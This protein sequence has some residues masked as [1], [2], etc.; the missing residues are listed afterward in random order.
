M[1]RTCPVLRVLAYCRAGHSAPRPAIRASTRRWPSPIATLVGFS[2]QSHR[3]AATRKESLPLRSPV[4]IRPVRF[5][6][7]AAGARP[8]IASSRGRSDPQPG[9]GRPLSNARRGMRGGAPRLLPR[10]GADQT[11]ACAACTV[12]CATSGSPSVAMHRWPGPPRPPRCPPPAYPARRGRPGQSPGAS[13]SGPVPSSSGGH[14][15]PRPR[16]SPASDQ[17]IPSRMSCSLTEHLAEAEPRHEPVQHERAAAD[18]V[19]PPGVHHADGGPGGPG[20]GQQAAGHG[21]HVGR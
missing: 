15:R 7:W 13:S 1:V 16:E 14:R 5:P 17:A 6:P 11:Q 18:H 21:V 4:K 2:A 19:N 20:L 12:H 10:A 3:Y 8:T 9:M